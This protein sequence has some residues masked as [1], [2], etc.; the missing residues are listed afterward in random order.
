MMALQKKVKPLEATERI[1]RLRRISKLLYRAGDGKRA[2]EIASKALDIE[3]EDPILGSFRQYD[4][5]S[6]HYR[7]IGQIERAKEVMSPFI[8]PLRNNCTLFGDSHN[9]AYAREFTYLGMQKVAKSK[10]SDICGKFAANYRMTAWQDVYMASYETGQTAPDIN[11]II[12]DINP[13]EDIE[14]YTNI[15]AFHFNRGETDK[16]NIFLEKAVSAIQGQKKNMNTCSISYLAHF[17]D[18]NDLLD[19]TLKKTVELIDQRVSDPAARMKSFN[20]LERCN[21][22]IRE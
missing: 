11:E 14:L 18:R 2:F 12:S 1:S 15:A 22:E 8:D 5:I 13:D 3:A 21:V 7:E 6:K 17:T 4:Y 10:I 20:Y 19:A 9:A 16:G